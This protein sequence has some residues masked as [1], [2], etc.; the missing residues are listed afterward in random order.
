MPIFSDQ[1]TIIAQASAIGAG[2]LALIRISGRNTLKNS[3]LFCKLASNIPLESVAS[4]TVH[5]GWIV[6]QN[7]SH[8][9]QVMFIVMHG[10]RTFTGEDTVEV[11]CHNNQFIVETIIQRALAC[12]M[13]LA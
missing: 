9:D 1:D 13:R 5:Y 8:L 11:T 12:G 10:P 6:Q 3:S 4:H 7:G 2:A